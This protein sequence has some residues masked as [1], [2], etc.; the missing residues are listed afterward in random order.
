LSDGTDVSKH[1]E[2]A[3]I[4]WSSFRD[5]LGGTTHI[6]VPEEILSLVRTVNNLQEL[7]VNFSEEEIDKVV[8]SLPIDKAPGPNGFNG[9]FL[10][11]C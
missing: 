6:V 4:L 5:R 3:T 7:S 9:Q 10:K 1:E 11:S 8:A 2:K